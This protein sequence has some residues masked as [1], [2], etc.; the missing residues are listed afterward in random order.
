MRQMMVIARKDLR[1]NLR[2][3]AFSLYLAISLA[4]MAVVGIRA[5]GGAIGGQI[6]DL[7]G[8]GLAP[9]EVITIIEPIM[10]TT[11][12][13]LALVLVMLLCQ[14]GNTHSLIMEKAKRS[15]ESLLC[16]PLSV[17]QICAGKSLAIFLPCVILGLLFAFATLA[18][19]DRVLLAP[20]A[21]QSVMPSAP[22]LAATLVAVSLIAFFLVSFLVALQFIISRIQWV[23]GVLMGLIAAIVIA[24]NY[25]LLTFGLEPWSIIVVSLAVAAVLA[26]ATIYLLRL[27]TKERIVLSSKG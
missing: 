12:F 10:G 8:Q 24:L 6:D 26:L 2:I 18:W 23:N 17:R 4:I 25:G 1:E 20:Q 19:A 27:A 3:G 5:L 15:L 7:L 21:G 14:Y 16:T 9:A 22:V 11:L 13:M